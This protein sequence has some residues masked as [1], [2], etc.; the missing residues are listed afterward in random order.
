MSQQSQ[1]GVRPHQGPQQPAQHGEAPL[2]ESQLPAPAQHAL[3]MN[4]S[5]IS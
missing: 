5:P 3:G 4:K 2:V 1:D